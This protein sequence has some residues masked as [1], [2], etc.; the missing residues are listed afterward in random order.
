MSV[1]LKSQGAG[2]GTETNGA[3]LNLVC[4]A[5]V[6]VNDILVAH[7]MHTG[8][9]TAPTTPSGWTLLYGPANVGTTATARHWVFGKIADGT[10][11]GATINF[12]TAGGTNGRAGRIYS[13]SG[14]VCGTIELVIP[15]AS[16][17]DIPHATD[18]QGPT[19]TTTMNGALAVAFTCQDDNNTEEAIAGASGGTWGGFQTFVD[20][21][22]GPQGLHLDIQVSTPTA[23]PGTISG[24]AMVAAND[25]AGT[26]G[27]EIRPVGIPTLAQFGDSHTVID[28]SP[29]G[30]GQFFENLGS[31]IKFNGQYFMYYVAGD[32]DVD[33]GDDYVLN[34]KLGVAT[35]PDGVNWTPYASN[36]IIEFEP[37]GGSQDE[38][39]V[40]GC[41]AVVHDGQVHLYYAGM[42]WISGGSVDA[43]I[44]YRVSDDGFTFTGD[45]L[46][47]AQENDEFYPCAAYVDSSD[48]FHVYY[49][50]PLTDGG[51]DLKRLS[52]ST[53]NA[54]TTN[55][56]V[57]T[58]DFSSLGGIIDVSADQLLLFNDLAPLNGVVSSYLIAKSSLGTL[59]ALARVI[60]PNSGGAILDFATQFFKDGDQWFMFS[61][62]ST[63]DTPPF[64]NT[65]IVCRTYP[66][67]PAFQLS[68]S[69]NIA[70]NAATDTTAILT[71][72]TSKDSGDF[73]AGKISDNTNPLPPINLASG[74]YTEVEFCHKP[75]VYAELGATYEFRI[76]DNGT[77]LDTYTE[78][79]ELTI[80]A[81]V[82]VSVSM[83]VPCE[84]TVGLSAGA[85]VP[86]EAARDLTQPLSPVIE[87]VA[88]ASHSATAPHA[89]KAD[90]LLGVVAPYESHGLVAAG[91]SVPVETQGPI[92]SSLIVPVEHGETLTADRTGGHEFQQPLAAGLDVSYE[93]SGFLA[94]PLSLP[95][96]QR[97]DL[98]V[99]RDV[100]HELAQSLL[101][102]GV[103]PDEQLASMLGLAVP[104][105]ESLVPGST[106][107]SVPVESILPLGKEF[108]VPVE[109]ALGVL[110]SGVGRYEI[111]A[112]NLVFSAMAV[113]CESRG[114]VG[115]DL[116][117]GYEWVTP[118]SVERQLSDEFGSLIQVDGELL[119]ESASHVALGLVGTLEWLQQVSVGRVSLSEWLAAAQ[120]SGTIPHDLLSTILQTWTPPW[121]ATEGA[122]IPV[123]LAVT[124][125]HESRGWAA[126]ARMVV[127]EARQTEG[128]DA[129]D[130]E[131]VTTIMAQGVI[132]YE[133][134]QDY[135]PLLELDSIES[136]V[137]FPIDR[138]FS[139]Y[140]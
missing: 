102:A 108:T 80:E 111:W 135:V 53:P 110:G 70:D 22:L 40:G 62:R 127:Y 63:A 30:W 27:F 116:S 18:P 55:G 105:T 43:E 139:L 52:G 104:P 36:P 29:S 44:R 129:I 83:V 118:V 35:S 134:Q 84:S 89:W 65:Q 64:S 121:E 126:V 107:G 120:R 32:A 13:F 67:I 99:S 69:A 131:W 56:T 68:P 24:G 97:A 92:V 38:E 17:S 46:I 20:A 25:E 140:T 31:V 79:A 88:E 58:T 49:V 136:D 75:T 101:S 59:G 26:I 16:F 71:A 48:A 113:P 10:E 137:F 34:R 124:L 115:V 82:P 109:S 114:L 12:G 19:V 8:T 78:Y 57:T 130:L 138:E 6:D 47:L 112:D 23:N 9:T 50:G 5:T 125:P 42:R 117:S 96:E 128:L 72:P 90:V 37:Q 51:G 106:E 54:I 61:T 122:L 77:P 4:P 21:S 73:Q 2:A 33:P 91:M 15:V 1:A 14:Y 94:G 133:S 7:V 41:V 119:S 132:P 103:V 28:A 45:T 66:D 86:T 39:G 85:S 81:S 11:D 76:T 74:L 98:A 93:G 87:R 123:S 60:D 3:A 100:R 95:F